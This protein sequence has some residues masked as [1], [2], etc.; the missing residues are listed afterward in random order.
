MNW[1]DWLTFQKNIPTNIAKIFP[2]FTLCRVSKSTKRLAAPWVIVKTR[3][4]VWSTGLQGLMLHNAYPGS[5][6]LQ[7]I[8]PKSWSF[9]KD[10]RSNQKL[11]HIGV[12]TGATQLLGH[13]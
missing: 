9:R 11:H 6:H 7:I 13:L 12:V 3:H 5:P 4:F 8:I 10:Y 2:E 1:L